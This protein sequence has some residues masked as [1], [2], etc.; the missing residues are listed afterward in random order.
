M[1]KN[2]Q[3]KQITV[4]IPH[5]K[6]ADCS[7]TLNSLA[8]QTVPCE[9]IMVEDVHAKGASWAR[10]EG[11]KKVTTPYVLFSDD[12]IDWES[13]ALEVMLNS[14]EKS[15]YSYAYGDYDLLDGEKVI[16][17]HSGE[18]SVRRMVDFNFVSTMSLI[19][20]KDF[21]G[22]DE[23]IKRFQDWDLWLN[24]LFNYD[25]YGTYTYRKLF[26][27]IKREGITFDGKTNIV[28]SIKIIRN[29]YHI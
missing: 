24:M 17:H 11:F 6:G 20:T 4:V 10:N 22:F 8:R 12:D 15:D 2:L 21:C 1:E 14:L 7:I 29:K 26:K 18:F 5:R 9:I 27:T 28:E 13:D 25:R 19:R 3:E 23:S 16:P